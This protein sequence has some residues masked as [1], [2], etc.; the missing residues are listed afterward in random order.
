MSET[1]L[2]SDLSRS[3]SRRQMT[4]L[5]L[6]SAIGTG[7]FLGAG[8]SISVAGPAVILSYLAGAVLA[9]IVAIALAEMTSALPVRGSF[10]AIVGRFLGPLAGFAVRWTYWF[11]LVVGIGSEV[12]AAAIYLNFWWPQVPI[13]LS[14]AVFSLLLTLVNLTHVRF[15][16]MAESVFAGIKV[17]AISVFILLGLVLVLFGLPGRPATGFGN[18]VSHGGFLPNGPSAVWLVMSIVVVAFAGIEVVAVSAP[19]ARQ[20]REALRSATRSVITR[21]SLFYLLSIVL[22]LAIRPWTELSRVHGLDGSPFVATFASADIP[23]AA[24]VTNF[25][26]IVTA[27]SAANA[28]L[29]AAARML[30]SL[31][32]D[33]FAPRRLSRANRHGLPWTATLASTVG[34]L[35]AAILAAYAGRATFGI[36][37]AT[38][39]F[40]IIATWI[41]ILVTLLVFRRK[42]P[43]PGSSIRLPGGPVLPV[44]G[45]LALLS[46]FATGIAVPDMRLA[47]FVGV[48]FV[49]TVTAVYALFVRRRVSPAAGES[50][51]SLVDSA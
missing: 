34:L 37:L 11:S 35:V 7:L 38:G 42:G 20:P 17:L 23:A 16:G 24:T 4:M 45:V 12:V 15:F 43:A 22:M 39:G 46:V 30:H 19:E 32:H 13:W 1:P 33:G 49:L 28:N 26:L 40:G 2:D 3:L 9:A 25:V 5:G 8:S 48:P 10:G 47:C 31:A 41:T 50:D 36:L 14:V 44:L 21:L 18:L 27:L 29:Y 51:T 6:G